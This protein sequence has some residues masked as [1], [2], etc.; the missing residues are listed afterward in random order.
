MGK[1]SMLARWITRRTLLHSIR[2]LKPAFS[3]VVSKHFVEFGLVQLCPIIDM[4][5]N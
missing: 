5:I 4:Y 3:T 2:V 1:D